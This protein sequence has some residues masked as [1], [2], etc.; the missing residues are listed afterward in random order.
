MGELRFDTQTRCYLCGRLYP[1]DPHHVFAGARKKQ[2][3]KDGA[4]VWLCRKCHRKVQE[5]ADEMLSLQRHIQKRMMDELG[6]TEEEFIEKYG[7][8]FIDD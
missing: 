5:N 1:L 4:I 7:R 6:W 3:D 2:S 8:S